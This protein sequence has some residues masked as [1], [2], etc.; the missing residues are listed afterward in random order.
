MSFSLGEEEFVAGSFRSLR[1]FNR[2]SEA[3]LIPL[4]ITQYKLE[5]EVGETYTADCYHRQWDFE[6]FN[7]PSHGRF[8]FEPI[9]ETVVVPAV[10]L[11]SFN[12]PP[13]YDIMSSFAETK[14][15]LKEVATKIFWTEESYSYCPCDTCA[16][17]F[18]EVVTVPTSEWPDFYMKNTYAG[19]RNDVS[20]VVS[21]V[22]G[23]Y[24][25][26]KAP[27]T[28]RDLGVPPWRSYISRS[29][30]ETGT[31]VFGVVE[32]FGKVLHCESGLRSEKI[33]VLG[34]SDFNDLYDLLKRFPLDV[35][36]SKK[37]EG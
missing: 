28:I 8:A 19:H 9:N 13:D 32:N 26:Y 31:T 10:R 17:N 14:T 2:N 23:F 33:K 29:A 18:K 30:V 5:Y 20:P 12:D 36:E 1:A 34:V 15:I 25:F 21:C 22:C 37:T 6:K 7:L 16:A 27:L 11:P 24:S 35:W 4:T 3:K